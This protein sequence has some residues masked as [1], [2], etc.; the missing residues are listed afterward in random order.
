MENTELY[1]VLLCAFQRTNADLSLGFDFSLH[2]STSISQIDDFITLKKTKEK[3]H[4]CLF[5]AVGNGMLL[6]SAGHPTYH[7][8]Y[9]LYFHS[10]IVPNACKQKSDAVNSGPISL[11]NYNQILTAVNYPLSWIFSTCVQKNKLKKTA[12]NEQA[13]WNEAK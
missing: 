9:S 5:S 7:L 10:R 3:W 4:E 12:T 13:C 6:T 2:L 11:N 1:R 8:R